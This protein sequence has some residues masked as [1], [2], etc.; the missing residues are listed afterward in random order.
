M[1]NGVG[2]IINDAALLVQ[3]RI[4]TFQLCAMRFLL[5]FKNSLGPSTCSPKIIIIFTT[6]LAS[7][8]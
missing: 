2:R 5:A 6:V 4:M 8:R 7:Y 1:I 3:A